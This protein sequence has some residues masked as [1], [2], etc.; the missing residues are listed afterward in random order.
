MGGSE[1]V[2]IYNIVSS[3]GRRAEVLKQVECRALV[4]GREHLENNKSFA[5]EG[6]LHMV[7]RSIE[8][9]NH[10]PARGDRQVAQAGSKREKKNGEWNET[11][12]S[13]DAR[14]V[15]PLPTYDSADDK[16]NA[17]LLGACY[18][19]SPYQGEDATRSG[20]GDDLEEYR[21]VQH[22]APPAYQIS[23]VAARSYREGDL[24]N[25]TR[26][27]RASESSRRGKAP[28]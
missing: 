2:R 15:A 25:G 12:G 18:A 7:K 11:G 1:K 19:A 5:D 23:T 8:G 21:R 28:R 6:E 27:V 9:V 13:L 17:Y 14:P 24:S 16:R 26:P 20:Y 3:G 22:T 4:S 10:K